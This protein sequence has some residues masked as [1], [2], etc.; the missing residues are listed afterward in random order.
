VRCGKTADEEV[1]DQ[2]QLAT[3]EIIPVAQTNLIGVI[4]ESSCDSV[5]PAPDIRWAQPHQSPDLTKT[6]ASLQIH[7]YQD[8]VSACEQM[9]PHPK[10]LDDTTVLHRLG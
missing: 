7:L 4:R 9:G 8:A 2:S 3:G 10:N 6:I 5:N 1:F